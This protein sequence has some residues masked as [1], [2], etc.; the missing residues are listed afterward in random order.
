[1]HVIGGAFVYD[2][3]MCTGDALSILAIAWESVSKFKPIAKEWQ[4]TMK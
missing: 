1:L 3:A 2:L 4:G